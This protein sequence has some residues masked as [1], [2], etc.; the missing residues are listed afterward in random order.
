MNNL[1]IIH[2]DNDIIVCYKP[3]GVATQTRRL[4]QQDMVSLLKNYRA[5]KKEP[6][7]IGVVH[8]LDQ[9]VEGI[10]VFAKNEK[11]AA[12]LSKQVADRSLGKY[13]YAIGQMSENTEGKFDDLYSEVLSGNGKPIVLTDYMTFDTR[14]NVGRILPQKPDAAQMKK[15]KNIKKAE[16]EYTVRDVKDKLVCMDIKLHTGRHHQIRLQMEHAGMPLVGDSK[17]GVAENGQQ[18]ALCSYRLEFN[19]PTSGKAL[20]FE[21]TPHNELFGWC[22]LH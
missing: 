2:E 14:T 16:L 22:R 19:H 21:I 7:Y 18:P 4:G 1:Q 15:D 20:D 9:P 6:A 10:M 8:R 12:N 3:A 13:Y 11:A 17:Y 5:K